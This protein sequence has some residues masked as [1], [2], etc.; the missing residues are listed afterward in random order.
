MA[1]LAG[2]LTALGCA[3]PTL[4][5]DRE[6]TREE[7]DPRQQARFSEGPPQRVFLISVAGLRPAD[8]LDPFGHAAADGALVPVSYTH[9]TLPTIYSV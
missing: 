3:T 8:Y 2:A 5:G 6:L 4:E 1:C 9:L 7:E